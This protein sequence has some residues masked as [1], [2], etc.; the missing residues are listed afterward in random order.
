M[1]MA[2]GLRDQVKKILENTGFYFDGFE[3]LLSTLLWQKLYFCLL[4]DLG[5]ARGFAY[6]DW[7]SYDD[8]KKIF[9]PIPM[10]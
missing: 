3:E 6:Q 5:V 8:F 7:I 4:W 10:V 2:K 9:K 1:W